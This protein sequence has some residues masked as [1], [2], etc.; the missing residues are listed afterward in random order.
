MEPYLLNTFTQDAIYIYINKR[1]QAL[2]LCSTH[3]TEQQQQ[4]GEKKKREREKRGG[5]RKRKKATQ[6][7]SKHQCLLRYG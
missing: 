7:M 3:L 4:Q 2:R 1:L 5:G 6:R